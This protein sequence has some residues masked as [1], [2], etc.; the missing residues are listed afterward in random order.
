M[1][2]DGREDAAD[3][4]HKMPIHY[5]EEE[6]VG[7]TANRITHDISG[8]TMMFDKILNLGFSASFSFI[9]AYYFMFKLDVTLALVSLMLIPV[10]VLWANFFTKKLNSYATKI[11][12]LSSLITAKLNENINGINIIKMFNYQKGAIDT[13][14]DTNSEF[15]KESMKEVRSEEH[16][17]E[18]QSQ[19]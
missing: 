18:L 17:S 6:P 19:R 7:K 1:T 9:L 14:N 12:E 13:F 2:K 16:T 8:I 4:I 11:N 5:F 15:M 10:Y 3:C